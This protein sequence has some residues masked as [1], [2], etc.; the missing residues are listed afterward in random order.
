MDTHLASH[1]SR[2]CS[3]LRKASLTRNTKAEVGLDC[4]AV[5]MCSLSV[6]WESIIRR[7]H[8]QGLERS[9]RKS[10]YLYILWEYRQLRLS[11]VPAV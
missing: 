3:L 8:R 7:N 10:K 5:V 1:L 2:S 11:V 4:V 6:L 9:R